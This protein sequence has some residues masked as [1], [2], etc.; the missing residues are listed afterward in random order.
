MRCGNTPGPW[1]ASAQTM[2]Q[3]VIKTNP[4][5]QGVHPSAS[6]LWQQHPLATYEKTIMTSH[7]K[8]S[9]LALAALAALFVSP[10]FAQDSYYYGGIGVGQARARI[11]DQRIAERL[12]GTGLTTGAVAH[13]ERHSA[14]KVFGGYQF[15]RY[16]GAE[17]GYFNLGRF[18][19]KADTV[20]TGT[21]QGNFR[22]QGANLD[23]VGTMPF[24]DRF[25]GLARVGVQYARTR[26]AITSS[27]AATVTDPRPS[28]REANAKIGLGLQYAI[29][30]SFF[31]RGEVERYRVSDAVGNHSQVAMYSVSMV[32]PFGR[33]EAARPRAMAT[34]VYDTPVAVAPA[35]AVAA[36]V[37]VVAPLP[38]A[39]PMAAFAPPTRRVSY[40]AESFFG[41][42]KSELRP[43][44]QQALD[45]F[46]GELKGTAYDTITVQGHADR[47]GS[48]EYNQTLSLARA[49]A[50]KTYLVGTGGLDSTKIATLGKSES[51]PVTLPEACKGPV[52]APVVACLQPD[53]RVEIEVTGSR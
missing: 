26:A 19:F 1:F 30:R 24:T 35:A 53:R 41:F 45:T 46:V 36:P 2:F 18:G 17:L 27:G 38:P 48:T 11:D 47:I 44:G 50:V 39:A 10:V 6:P 25:S 14:Y 37:V 12:A 20:P 9:L 22:V 4:H 40:A 42:D 21:L 49:E 32:F 33:A 5:A 43:E 23:L 16:F 29:S 15:N 8:P 3:R 13:D 52:S 7:H 34:P 31:V 28:D 51:Q